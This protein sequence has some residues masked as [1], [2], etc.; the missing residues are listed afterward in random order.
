MN[1]YHCTENSECPK[2]FPHL[3]EDKKECVLQDIKAI[4]NFI[5]KEQKIIE[6]IIIF[7]CLIIII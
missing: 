2:E 7:I 5:A 6:L 4:E 3:I 1:N